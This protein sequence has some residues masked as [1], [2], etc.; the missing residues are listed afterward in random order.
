MVWPPSHKKE[1]CPRSNKMLFDFIIFGKKGFLFFEFCMAGYFF[2][3]RSPSWV[4]EGSLVWE[5]QW[6]PWLPCC[7]SPSRYP[8][9]YL[10]FLKVGA[11]KLAPR[12]ACEL[13]QRGKVLWSLK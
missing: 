9:K 2:P 13:P 3:P 1:E 5:W 10:D 4:Q 11:S 7:C 8:S 6:G 12:G